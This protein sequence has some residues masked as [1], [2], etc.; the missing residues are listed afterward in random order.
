[1]ERCRAMMLKWP[2][3]KF[4]SRGSA[5]MNPSRVDPAS[6]EESVPTSNAI[7]VAQ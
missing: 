6:F 1:M 4:R 5:T 2:S 7:E 3:E